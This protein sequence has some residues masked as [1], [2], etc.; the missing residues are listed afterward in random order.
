MK[1][2]YIEYIFDRDYPYPHLVETQYIKK[3]PRDARKGK[4]E[5]WVTPESWGVWSK[6]KRI[7][8]DID[9]GTGVQTPEVR[10]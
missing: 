2:K 1:D 3:L 5:V 10:E 9:F 6:I 8:S 4:C 7:G